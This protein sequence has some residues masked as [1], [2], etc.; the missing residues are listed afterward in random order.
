MTEHQD[1]RRSEHS[2]G[3]FHARNRIIV[4]E[5]AGHAADEQVSAPAIE[6]IF[7][8]DPRVRAAQDGRI[9]VLTSDQRFPFSLEVVAPRFAVN[10]AR[11]S[12]HQ[13]LERGIRRQYILRLGRRLLLGASRV[14]EHQPERRCREQNDGAPRGRHR[15]KLTH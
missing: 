1:Q 9:G 11:I 3:V 4:G 15:M 14:G 12:F 7:G 10:I 6:G 13:F 5:I 8:R 2:D